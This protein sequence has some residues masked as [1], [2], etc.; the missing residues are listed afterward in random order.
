VV[1]LSYFIFKS[2]RPR[3]W[4]KNLAVF[5]G[6]VFTGW[7]FYPEKFFRA[8]LAFFIFSI[9]TSSVYIFNDILD[10]PSDREH[11]L[12]KKRPISSG[13]LP[14]PIALFV[15]ITGFVVSLFLAVNL[16]FFFFFICLAYLLIHVVY[17]LFLKKMPILDVLAI[18]TGFILRV[19]AGAVIIN[20][21]I[22]IWLLL[23]VV[24]FSLFLA[25]GKRRSELTL[26]KGVLTNKSRAVLFSYPEKLLDL[27][28]SMFA[29]TTWLTYAWFTFLQPMVQPRGKFLVLMADLPLAFRSQKWL[30]LTVPLVIYGI[31]RYLWLIYEKNKGE[32]PAR[33]LTSDRSLLITIV[34]WGLMVVGIIYG[35][36]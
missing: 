3:Q 34:I 11:P 26:L 9:L 29:N 27:Y 2:A 22:D 18:A 4:I 36:G 12:K 31:M 7:L 16:S 25:V 19:W 35:L 13:Q 33:V 30:M 14:I 20:T 23:C 6:L 28:I 17:A 10:A 5:T 8:L 15:A 32:S 21:H 24:S 1:K